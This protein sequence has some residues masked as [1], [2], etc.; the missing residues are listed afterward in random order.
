MKNF[1]FCEVVASRVSKET[2]GIWEEAYKV[3]RY[4]Q[5][6]KLNKKQ[7]D[8]TKLWT[9]FLYKQFYANHHKQDSHQLLWLK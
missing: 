2:I 5:P 1:I 4:Q 9:F 6:E 7:T 8:K 3:E